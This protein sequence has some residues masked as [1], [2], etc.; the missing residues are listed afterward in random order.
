MTRRQHLI[1]N[2]LQLGQGV[3]PPVDGVQRQAD[4][5]LRRGPVCRLRGDGGPRKYPELKAPC[6]TLRARVSALSTAERSDEDL[7]A[8]AVRASAVAYG[9]DLA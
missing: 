5:K 8:D 3:G 9:P 4:R 2:L 6:V 7:A 1:D